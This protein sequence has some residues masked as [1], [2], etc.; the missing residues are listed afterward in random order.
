MTAEQPIPGSQLN[1]EL[2]TKGKN[3]YY[4]MREYELRSPKIFMLPAYQ[5][6]IGTWEKNTVHILEIDSHDSHRYVMPH[7]WESVLKT[8]NT[9][10]EYIR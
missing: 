3:K 2:K 10:I 5:I 1:L 4:I 8:H 6:K 9:D 7:N